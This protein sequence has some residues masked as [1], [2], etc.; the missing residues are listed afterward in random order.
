M[1]RAGKSWL[2][3]DPKAVQSTAG[4]GGAA[5]RARLGALLSRPFRSLPA[6]IVT[7]VF[8][9]ALVT[10]LVVSWISTHSI[11]SFLREKMDE[12]LSGAAARHQP[13]H[14]SLL[15]AASARRR[16][17]RA[18]RRRRGELARGSRGPRPTRRAREL[19]TY[20]SYVLEHF[21]QYEALFVLDP[22]R[23]RPCSGSASS[24]RSPRSGAQRAAR[25]TRSH[26]RRNRMD[27]RAARAA[28][29]GPGAE[30]RET[31]AIASL[32]ALIADRRGRAAAAGRGRGAEPRA[33]DRRG[34]TARRCSRRR[35]PSGGAPTPAPLPAAARQPATVE[36]YTDADGEHRVGSAL[37]L[38]RFGWTLVVEQP[39]EDAFAPVVSTIR[40]QM[41]LNL[42]I[43]LGFSLVAFQV[44]RSIVRPILALSDAAL[45]IATGRDRRDGGRE[46]RGGRDRRADARL[47]RDVRAPAAQPARARGEPA[48]GRGRQLRG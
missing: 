6:R 5:A 4:R 29:V 2:M 27:R 1:A 44:A 24:S 14:R 31:S 32:H 22:G 7:S 13:A 17:L 19:R 39:Y 8:S 34:A 37:R 20:L 48:R 21:P 30:S 46:P 43:V 16:D 42:G 36:D 9:A 25:V 15:R 47:Q 35:T 3:P 26:A 28:R 23:S 10:S 33:L 18:Q 12:K 45:R 11:E 41:L 40:E 38:G